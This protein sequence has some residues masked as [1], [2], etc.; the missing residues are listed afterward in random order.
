M[1][2][3]IR[4]ISIL[5]T[6]KVFGVLYFVFGLLFAL[7]ILVVGFRVRTGGPNIRMHPP[8]LLLVLAPILYGV[9]AFVGSAVMGWIYNQVAKRI[10]GI[11]FELSPPE[12]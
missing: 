4:S 1:M 2:Q 5:Q 12:N 3:Q 11:E 6:A 10:G 8:L 9:V 7:I